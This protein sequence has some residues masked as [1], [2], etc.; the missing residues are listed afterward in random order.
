M[1]LV[2]L[3]LVL[4]A[5][6][7]S[8]SAATT[9]NAPTVD[10][11]VKFAE[12][13]SVKISPTGKY[14]AVAMPDGD[15]TGLQ[16]IDISDPEAGF[17]ATAAYRFSRLEHVAQLYWSSDERV[18]FETTR[19]TD[20]VGDSVPRMTGRIYAINADGSDKLVIQGSKR[21]WTGEFALV[22]DPLREDPDHVLIYRKHYGKTA[23]EIVR[24]ATR[25]DG[26]SE[27]L[28]T[29]PFTSKYIGEDG[30]VLDSAL[31]VRVAWQRDPFDGSLHFAYRKN[32]QAE[33]SV[34]EISRERSF[35]PVG[36]LPDDKSLVVQRNGKP[37][38]YFVLDID[39]MTYEPLL[40]DDTV[41][42]SYAIHNL[43]GRSVIGAAFE[44]GKLENRFIDKEHPDARLYR[45]LE[46]AF[47][48]LHVRITSATRDNRLAV[49]AVSADRLPT[50]Y[51][52]FDARTNQASFLLASRQWLDPATLA[53]R[54]PVRFEARDGVML[55]GYLTLPRGRKAENLPLVTIVH[56]GPH[57]IRHGSLFDFEAQLLASRGYAVLQTNFRGSGG[58]GQ[59][60]LEA[61]WRNWGRK[62]Q[63][64]IADGVN[65]AVEQGIADAERLCIYG[66]SF[67]GYSVLA[68]LT[69]SPDLFKCGFAFVGIYDLEMM[70]DVGD[71][72][73]RADGEAYLERVLGTDPQELREQSPV[74]HVDQI[75]AALYVAHGREDVRAHVNHYLALLDALDAA[76]IE[77]EKMLKHQEGHGFYQM[78]NRVE[79]Y[80]ELVDFIDRHIGD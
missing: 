33:W 26:E 6:P 20:L 62:I 42:A 41:I 48:G 17:K 22:M 64:D 68:Q 3:A 5:L 10:D 45:T 59:P 56:G 8:T 16:I 70:F 47:E 79:L 27:I 30:F 73:Y 67:G 55:H 63:D 75:E 50:D 14:L 32:N 13:T 44:D 24:L 4:F 25:A 77:Y 37:L 61:G 39:S 53:V 71:V 28:A 15:Q 11:F 36:F 31:N 2:V 1:R 23:A 18:V 29:T 21:N 43:N 54:K 74:H 52:L 51:Y 72:S 58:Y 38:G 34:R 40:T 57:G 65:W 49:I 9:G 76:G 35:T 69:R 12:F 66:A 19:E 78:D 46:Q 80:S 7:V 60:F